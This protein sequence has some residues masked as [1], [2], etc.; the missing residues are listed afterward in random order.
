MGGFVGTAHFASPEQLEEKDIDVRSDVYSLGVTLWYML[1]GGAPFIG[2]LA[3]VMSAHLHKPPPFDKLKHVPEPVHEVLRHMLEKDQ[4]KRLQT[5][6]ETRK[7]LEDCIRVLTGG[8]AERMAAPEV[9]L[10][11]DAGEPGEREIVR[12]T[13][14]T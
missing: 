5:P 11:P 14:Y 3:Q 12:R 13:F 1:A 2:S 9:D 7:E 8:N 10:I 4:S 6:V